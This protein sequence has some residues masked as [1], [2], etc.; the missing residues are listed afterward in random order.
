MTVAQ[1]QHN[2]GTAIRRRVVS[3]S[4][5]FG[6]PSDSLVVEVT[7][8]T[9]PWLTWPRTHSATVTRTGALRVVE[10]GRVVRRFSAGQWRVAGRLINIRAEHRSV[11]VIDLEASAAA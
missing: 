4:N 3:A 1:R 2:P 6:L 8:M 7:S 11:V 10:R 5:L 9:T